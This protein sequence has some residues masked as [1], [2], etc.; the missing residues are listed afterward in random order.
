M[1]YVGNNPVTLVDPSGQLAFFW[2]RYLTLAAALNSGYS[3]GDSWNLAHDAMRVDFEFANPGSQA[4]TPEG[5][6]QHGMSCCGQTESQAIAN[7]NTYIQNSINAGNRGSAIHAAQD[8]VTPQHAG[9][10]WSG[11]TVSHVLGDIFP[12][13]STIKQAYQNTTQILRGSRNS[14]GGSGK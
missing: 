7:T 3:F 10:E 2:H 11:Y 5:V 8:L 13:L 1:A 12:S 9:H 6:R 14:G 4:K